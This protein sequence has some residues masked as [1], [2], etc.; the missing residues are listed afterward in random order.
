MTVR[1]WNGGNA[2]LRQTQRSGAVVARGLLSNVL[3]LKAINF[4][5]Q[6]MEPLSLNY[7]PATTN[8]HA[9]MAA[10]NVEA[11]ASRLARLVASFKASVALLSGSCWRARCPLCTK[12]CS[13]LAIWL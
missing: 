13:V 3:D 11:C 10:L 2:G 1:S 4:Q 8:A 6:R 5:I 7:L 12:L 9:S